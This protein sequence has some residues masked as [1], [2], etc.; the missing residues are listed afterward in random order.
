MGLRKTYHDLFQRSFK[1]WERIGFHVTRVSWGAP[2]PDTRTLKEDL[3]RKQ[4]RLVGIDMNEKSQID[5]LSLFSAKFK[6]E[7]EKIPKNKTPIPY[8]YYVK[9]PIFPI[10]DADILYCMIR[11]FKPRR[12]IEIGSGYSTYLSAEAILKNK[13]ENEKCGCE[14]IAIEPYPNE[15]LRAGFPGLS[16]LVPKKAEDVPLSEFEKLKKNDVLFIDSSHTLAIGND[17]QYEYLEIIPS[18]NKGVI[19][20]CHD[21]FLPLEYPRRWVLKEH[22]FYSEQYLLQ[23]FLAFNNA[24]E[25]LW[26]GTYMCLKHPDKMEAAFSSY[27]RKEPYIAGSFW[28]R[29]RS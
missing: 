6:K 20:H 28:I 24:F 16:Q 13:E 26:A 3:W 4:S 7:Y 15:T 9:N 10:V 17:V 1:V 25:V 27:T 5:L 11:H 22:R 21:V 29:R 23:T 2:I 18:L 14:L 19:V 12:I 8:K